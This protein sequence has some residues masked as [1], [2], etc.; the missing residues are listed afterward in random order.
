MPPLA[1]ALTSRVSAL[2]SAF[3]ATPS[4]EYK[5]NLL[6][7]LIDWLT[8]IDSPASRVKELELSLKMIGC[9]T[10]ISLDAVN[11]TFAAAKA[12]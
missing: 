2:K 9:C 10:C 4:F 11:N 1:F 7:P 5:F 12:D 3:I 6:R 8:T